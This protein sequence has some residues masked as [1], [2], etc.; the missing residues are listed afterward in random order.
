MD[1][2]KLSSA[3]GDEA[4]S[5]TAGREVK[6]IARTGNSARTIKPPDGSADRAELVLTSCCSEQCPD[7]AF[8][9]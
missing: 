5:S 4:N 1:P 2:V 9:C 6:L 7:F 8:P 3:G